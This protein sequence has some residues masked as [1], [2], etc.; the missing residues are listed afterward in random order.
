MRRALT[1]LGAGTWLAGLRR[2]Q[3]T[4]RRAVPLLERRGSRWKLCPVADWNDQQVWR[5]LK[6]H[7]LP[8]HPLWEQGYVSIGDTHSTR[9]LQAGMAE[10][11]TRFFG[12]K[13][14]CG[15][16]LEV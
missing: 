12:F 11:D 16:H 6:A 4:S 5:Y 1:E 2:V 9:P 3:S 15:L 8:Y 14:E 7:G 13:R 10:E